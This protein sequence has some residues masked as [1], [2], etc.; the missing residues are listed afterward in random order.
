MRFTTRMR[1][2][3]LLAMMTLLLSGLYLFAQETTGGLQGTVR[4]AS[5]A[6][7]GGAH[8]ALGGSTLAGDKA[9]DTEPT[10][11][12]RFANSASQVIH[13]GNREGLQDRKARRLD[14]GSRPPAH[15]SH[16]VGG[17]DRCRSDRSDRSGATD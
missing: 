12:Y 13:R 9:L 7:V 11:Y 10:G 1:L 17:G 16:D 15:G 8:V 3:A 2:C 14:A 5:G 4:D 6:V